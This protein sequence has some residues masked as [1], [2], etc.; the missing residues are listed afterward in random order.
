M[1]Q[2]EVNILDFTV[3]RLNE[4]FQKFSNLSAQLNKFSDFALGVIVIEFLIPG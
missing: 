1:S 3:Y 2:K 4:D